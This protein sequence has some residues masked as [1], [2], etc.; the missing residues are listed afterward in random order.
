MKDKNFREMLAILAPHFA[1]V[2]VTVP[3]SLRA[4]TRRDFGDL[5]RAPSITFEPDFRAALALAQKEPVV[6]CTGSFYLVGAIIKS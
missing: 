6:L 4:A 3:P 1:R 5:L 2:I